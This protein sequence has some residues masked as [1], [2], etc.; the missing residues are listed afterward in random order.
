MEDDDGIDTWYVN[1][2][3]SQ[4]KTRE[5]SNRRWMTMT[6]EHRWEELETQEKV[7]VAN[8]ILIQ[9]MCSPRSG[10]WQVNV[11]SF[12]I[13]FSYLSWNPFSF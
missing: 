10:K 6:S 12:V 5:W 8:G 7:C 9:I 1:R 11:A 13:I 4:M 2:S 3:K